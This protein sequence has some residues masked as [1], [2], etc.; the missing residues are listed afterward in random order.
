MG[1]YLWVVEMIE[2][3]KWKPTFGIGFTKREG[4]RKLQE[5]K[6]DNPDDNFRLSKYVSK[7]W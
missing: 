5:Y 6:L 1:N 7:D 3:G 2:R 4:I